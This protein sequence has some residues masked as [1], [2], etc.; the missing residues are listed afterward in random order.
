MRGGTSRSVIAIA[1]S[2]VI[3]ATRERVWR[4]LSEPAEL[5]RWDERILALEQPAPDYPHGDQTTRWRYRLGSVPVG[6][7]DRPVEVV[8]GKRLRHAMAIGAFR[9]EE[10]YTLSEEGEDHT[11]LSL[12]L[13]APSNPVPVVGGALDRFDVR[14]LAAEIV[15][16]N[17]RSIQTWC[18]STP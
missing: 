7:E 1:M 17:L 12:R 14:Q 5:I 13:A 10:T 18:E 8:P 3:H 15:D 9:F 6:L 4:A 16:E 2:T 11:R